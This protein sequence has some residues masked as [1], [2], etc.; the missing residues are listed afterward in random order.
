M[1]ATEDNGFIAQSKMMRVLT[2]MVELY[3]RGYTLAQMANFLDC[4][5]RTAYRYIKLIESIGVDV[6]KDFHNRYFACSENCPFCHGAIKIE[7][8]PEA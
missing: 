5:E 1:K 2:L 6:D 8:I 7:M 3:K 4:S